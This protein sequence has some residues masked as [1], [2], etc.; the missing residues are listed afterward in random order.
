VP[1]TPSH[2]VAVLPFARTPLAPAALAIGAMAPDIPY[3][4]PLDV[5]R[6]LT[7]SLLG[8]TT[9]DLVVG[10]LT[11]VLWL[12]V[13]RAPALDYSPR[14]LAE[15]MAPQA[16]WRVRGPVVSW[17]LVVAALEIGILTHLV[18]DLFTHKGGLLTDLAPW[19]SQRVG[20]FAIANI[21]HAVVSLV[22]AGVLAWW[23]RRWALRTPRAERATRLRAG[24]RLVTWLGLAAV[25]AAVGLAWWAMGIAAGR[26]PLNPNLLGASFFVAAG[27]TAGLSV[28]LAIVWRLRRVQ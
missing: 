11:L 17:L 18:L 16:R 12:L 28:A 13:L 26:H 19:T 1:F 6:D 27:V 3:F 23:V 4:L 15:R 24:E 5:D 10:L 20:T 14:W 7:H 9:I 21:I 2:V 22:T 25:L 8:A